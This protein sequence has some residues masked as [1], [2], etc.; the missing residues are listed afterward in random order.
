MFSYTHFH[1]KGFTRRLVL[2]LRSCETWN[3]PELMRATLR[4][5]TQVEVI[6]SFA[7][8]VDQSLKSPMCWQLFTQNKYLT[9]RGRKLPKKGR[10]KE[11]TNR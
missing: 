10:V 5:F 8:F 6:F 9:S 1:N 7:F 2:M 11:G 4:K 3:W